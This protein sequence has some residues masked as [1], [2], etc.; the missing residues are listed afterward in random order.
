MA[1]D[2]EVTLRN[3]SN[4]D[5]QLQC[6]EHFSLAV[7]NDWNN[8]PQHIIDATKV[9]MFKNC[10]D[11]FWKDMGIYSWEAI[12]LIIHKYKYK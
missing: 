6:E 12:K 9:N 2:Y 8:L 7:I 4:R 5:V 3:C 10:L 1:M 11:K